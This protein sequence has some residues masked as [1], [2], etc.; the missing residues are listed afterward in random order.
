[1]SI[2]ELFNGYNY[3]PEIKKTTNLDNKILMTTQA[4]SQF[5]ITLTT[6]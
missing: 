4:N 2:L 3:Y 6:R 1:M 5:L